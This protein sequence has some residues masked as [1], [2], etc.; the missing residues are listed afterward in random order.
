M[1]LSTMAETPA[2]ALRS[3]RTLVTLL[4]A[5]LDRRQLAVGAP[6]N[7]LVGVQTG[8]SRPRRCRNAAKVKALILVAASG[9]RSP[10]A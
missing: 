1:T 8:P 5:E 10:S 6:A 9:C 3:Y 2:L 7:T 4:N